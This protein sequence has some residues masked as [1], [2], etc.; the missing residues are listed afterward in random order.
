MR[1]AFSFILF[2][3]C[4]FFLFSSFFF[5]GGVLLGIE[6]QAS[7]MLGRYFSIESLVPK[8]SSLKRSGQ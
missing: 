7:H 3:Y 4:F 6:P 2:I 8:T 5:L 1:T